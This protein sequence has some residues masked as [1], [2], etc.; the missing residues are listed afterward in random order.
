MELERW[1]L[2]T[3]FYTLPLE[4]PIVTITIIITIIYLV[5]Y[6][7]FYF[8]LY[9]CFS[10]LPVDFSTNWYYVSPYVI[11]FTHL[12]TSKMICHPDSKKKLLVTVYIHK[13]IKTNFVF[14]INI[15]LSCVQTFFSDSNIFCVTLSLLKAPPIS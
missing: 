5:H 6:F 11:M 10:I 4:S 9:T 13:I 12:I 3:Q 8:M 14:H 1:N 15:F 7:I 2:K